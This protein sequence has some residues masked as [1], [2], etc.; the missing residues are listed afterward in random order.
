MRTIQLEALSRRKSLQPLNPS[1]PAL[2]ESRTKF[3]QRIID[4]SK[5]SYPQ[6]MSGINLISKTFN[7]DLQK[8]HDPIYTWDKIN[9]PKLPIGPHGFTPCK[10]FNTTGCK[11]KSCLHTQTHTGQNLIVAHFCIIC[12]KMINQ[13]KFH[14]ARDCLTIQTLDE[15]NPINPRPLISLPLYC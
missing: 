8:I 3:V 5:K 14:P 4:E 11:I 13:L 6:L 15:I 9:G 1:S 7:E 10:F 2:G 12:A